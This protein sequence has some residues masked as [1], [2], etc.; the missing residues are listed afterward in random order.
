[1]NWTSFRSDFNVGWK[2]IKTNIQNLTLNSSCDALSKWYDSHI[3]PQKFICRSH[4]QPWFHMAI[5]SCWQT[6]MKPW[7]KL[8]SITLSR[9]NGKLEWHS[10]ETELGRISFVT[11]LFL[12]P[13]KNQEP[14][15]LKS[16]PVS[17]WNK[18]KNN[19]WPCFG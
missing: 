2:K 19:G 12:Y 13:I 18:T 1:M 10:Q 9:S 15:P 17:D 16:C 4:F 6:Q 5:L 8:W 14:E 3:T 7:M 11:E